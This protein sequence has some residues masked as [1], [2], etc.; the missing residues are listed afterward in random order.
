MIRDAKYVLR[1][2]VIFIPLPFFWALFDQQGSRWTLQAI[3][4]DG[5]LVCNPT[6]SEYMTQRRITGRCEWVSND[7]LSLQNN[8]HLKPDQIETLNPIF[9]VTLIPLF[10]VTLY[11]CLR[12]FKIPFTPLRR[13]TFGLIL[14]GLSFIFA[15]I[16]Q[17]Q[18]EARC[19]RIFSL[20][21][22]LMCKTSLETSEGILRLKFK[23]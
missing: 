13:M 7:I 5:H 8:I 11:P 16:L 22:T 19:H 15:A 2:L 20:K 9:I 4:L 6:L 1:I 18:I 3:E 23:V 10:E 17:I 21:V 12:H 14:A